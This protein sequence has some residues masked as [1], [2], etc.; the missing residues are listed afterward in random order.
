MSNT[1]GYKSFFSYTLIYFKGYTGFPSVWLKPLIAEVTPSRSWN[2]IF[3]SFYNF[4]FL[5]LIILMHRLLLPSQLTHSLR[6]HEG[7][8]W[9][10]ISDDSA[11]QE[12]K[13]TASHWITS[14]KAAFVVW[15][16]SVVPVIQAKLRHF[17][18]DLTLLLWFS[19][20]VW[21]AFAAHDK[22]SAVRRGAVYLYPPLRQQR[23]PRRARLTDEI[24]PQL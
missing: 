19:W 14:E 4:L 21:A 12:K 16:V 2:F 23:Q 24:Y 10:L 20:T 15:H 13:K 18:E 17:C 6:S 22:S 11:P 7:T 3:F 9:H 5:F 1:R 8:G